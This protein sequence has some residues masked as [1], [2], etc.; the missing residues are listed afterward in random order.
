MAQLL[1]CPALDFDSGLDLMVGG[2]EPRVGLC[3][4]CTEAA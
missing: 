3:A 1:K 2:I 4:N